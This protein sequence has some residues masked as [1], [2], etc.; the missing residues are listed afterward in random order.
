MEESARIVI[1]LIRHGIRYPKK[2]PEGW[3]LEQQVEEGGALT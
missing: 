1:L 2:V 3:P